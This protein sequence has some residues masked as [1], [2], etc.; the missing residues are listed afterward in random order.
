MVN[1]QETQTQLKP[2]TTKERKQTFLEKYRSKN[3]KISYKRY[4]GSPLR[5][6]GGKSLAVGL[7]IEHIP[8]N[9]KKIV[10]PFFGGGS[11]EMACAKELKLKVFGYDV[12]DILMNYWDAQ[13][14]KPEKLYEKLLQFTPDRN[15]FRQVK[16]QLKK[17]W[18]KWI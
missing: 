13:I 15:T 12:F 18:L 16:E 4:V 10:S 7:I 2:L 11:V 5:Y 17:H 3:G 1:W 14:K 9:V 8:D 6:A